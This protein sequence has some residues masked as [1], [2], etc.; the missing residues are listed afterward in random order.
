MLEGKYTDAYLESAGKDAPKFTPE[1]LRVISEPVD[2][3]GIN[4][5]RPSFYT[6]AFDR[7]PGYREVPFSKSHPNTFTSWLALGPEVL[8][9]GP[10]HVQSLWN[11]KAIYITENGTGAADELAQDG[12]VYDTDRI[13]FLRGFL[14]QLQRATADGAPVKGYFLWSMMDNFEWVDGY[15]NRF[16]LVY[17]DFE[18]QKRTPK[19]SARFFRE[20]ST[21]NA[22]V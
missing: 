9:W 7:P 12:N 5:Y 15:G 19:M 4:V 3:V 8:Y 14:T 2:F 13:M 18:T 11:P 16:G 10:K 17:V 1:D 22:V 6:L 21:R 20:V